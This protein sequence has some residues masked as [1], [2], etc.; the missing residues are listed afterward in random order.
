MCLENQHQR[1][2]RPWWWCV[3]GGVLVQMRKWGRE[4]KGEADPWWA[5]G[6]GG[7]G[8][9]VFPEGGARASRGSA[10][11]QQLWEKAKTAKA[12]QPLVPQPYLFFN[13]NSL[14]VMLHHIWQ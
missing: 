5:N 9:A 3:C 8:A 14:R 7:G 2:S 1:S 11:L 13:P 12:S 10:S 6:G 4:Q